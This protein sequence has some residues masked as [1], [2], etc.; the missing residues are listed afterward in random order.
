MNDCKEAKTNRK[1]IIIIIIIHEYYYGGAV[2][3]LLQDHLTMSVSRFAGYKTFTYCRL[4][5]NAAKVVG[6]I[7]RAGFLVDYWRSLAF[8]RRQCECMAIRQCQ[9]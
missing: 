5:N 8:K 4:K 2:A 6:A 1:F 7:S 3:L 9:A